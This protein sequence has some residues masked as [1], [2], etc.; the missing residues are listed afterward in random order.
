MRGDILEV[1]IPALNPTF[2]SIAPTGE[3]R[4][5]SGERG[6]VGKRERERERGGEREI[7]REG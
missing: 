2:S 6:R 7:G 1:I 5:E 4:K 3:R